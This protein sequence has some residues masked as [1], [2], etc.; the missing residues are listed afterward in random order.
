MNQPN[1]PLPFDIDLIERSFAALA[2]R[3][4]ELVERFYERLFS[5]YPGVRPLF[6]N[7]TPEEQRKKLL[8]SL[9]TVVNSLRKPAVLVEVLAELGL[10]HE[11]YGAEPAHYDAVA[12]TLLAVL[13]EMAGELWT[14]D[15]EAAWQGALTAINNQ[16]LQAYS[17][18][19]GA[20]APAPDP[21][22]PS[23]AELTE[24]TS[25]DTEAAFA[26]SAPETPPAAFEP[27]APPQNQPAATALAPSF[28]TQPETTSEAQR[29]EA[30]VNPGGGSGNS[31][32]ISE[33]ELANLRGQIAA[34]S[35]SQAVIEFQLDGTIITANDNFLAAVGYT[36]E[37]IQGK[38]HRIFCDPAYTQTAEYQ[39]LW[40]RLG[41]GQFDSGQYMRF[42]KN[43]RQ[44]WIQASYNPIFG[45]DGKPFKVVKYASD[46]T[47]QKTREADFSGQLSAIS[48]SQAVIE[49]E[50]DGTILTANDNFLAAVGYT[51]EEIRGRHHQIFCDPSY[52][53]SPEYQQF[54]KKLSGGHFDAG[55][56]KRI[57]KGGKEI[58]IQASYN[59]IL[60]PDGKPFK[61]VKYATDITQQK[62]EAFQNERFRSAV[63]GLETCLMM[64]DTDGQIIYA[65]PAVIQMMK[66]REPELRKIFS[67]FSADKLI[68]QSYDIF[69]QDPSHQRGLLKAIDKLP[70]QA[71]IQVAG[72]EFKV[73][74]TAILDS[75][76]NWLGNAVEW[77]DITEQK[78]A[79]REIANLIAKAA[80]GDLDERL[81]AAAFEG[82]L[83]TMAEGI[84]SL[85]DAVVQPV[86]E[87]GR[88]L[89][90]LAE[91][92]LCDRMSGD[93]Q[94]EF[95]ALRDALNGSM[96]HLHDMVTKI[97]EGSSSISSAANEL[98]EGNVELSQRTEEQAS[99][100]E[101]TASSMEELTGTVQQN[102]DN[103]RQANQLAA[104]AREQAEKGG[105][106]VSRA[107]S[108]MAEINTASKKISDIIGVIDEI[109]FQTNLL[110]LN[111]AVEA[112]RAGE[113][114]RGFAVVA[115][116]VR[117]LAQRS[118]TAAKEIKALIQDS[119]DK[120]QDGTRLV[121]ESGKTLEEIVNSVKKVSD[122]IAEIAAASREQSSGI[123]QVNQAI[124]Q[125]DQVT[126][127]NQAMVE[128]AAA[129]SEAL[130]EQAKS[131]NSMMSFFRID[132]LSQPA[133]VP[134]KPAASAK[135]GRSSAESP[136]SA[137]PAAKP[138]PARESRRAPAASDDDSEW[139]DF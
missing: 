125:M 50:L 78:T 16:M 41:S 98:S 128:Q 93:F 52:A 42:G 94:G 76:G 39:Q 92:D 72:L 30:H 82:F 6:Q 15:V 110:A 116:E 114:G 134:T 132:G 104:G 118:A 5:R 126:Q 86:R 2:P 135:P 28:E 88:V 49:F 59:P 20:S 127:K 11:Q 108:A 111:A 100:L 3:G 83:R 87:T 34:I 85:V 51:L 1:N 22:M 81:D 69:H 107:I 71:E 119:V 139:A 99:S 112:A 18:P 84:N 131:L 29:M 63:S 7:T 14:D 79:E 102:A 74:A 73:N 57:G 95:G 101:E 89:T 103:A 56:Y 113:Q 33:L 137:A 117:N 120:V 31:A 4:D 47:E 54:W 40:Q 96:S 70:A 43:G 19:G 115:A 97:L 17:Q 122:I 55:Q 80:V 66:R 13:E 24:D 91:G 61:V 77:G 44:I 105:D 121:D 90:S 38:H 53:Q 25:E 23:N 46:I 37:E 48:K 9:K 8:A 75:E 124:T 27:K 21:R 35:K 12:E 106:V 32:Q 67:G 65:N 64:A 58:W 10:R 109:A 129:A 133:T 68:G 130:D 123:Q 36:L 138:K 62:M 60:G 45:P 26:P 136:R